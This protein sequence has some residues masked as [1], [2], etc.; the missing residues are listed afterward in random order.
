MH[1]EPGEARPTV[2]LN[3][4]DDEGSLNCKFERSL[5]RVATIATERSLVRRRDLGM[6]RWRPVV[7]SR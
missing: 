2:I 3:R 1:L 7:T 5:I 4:A 6:T